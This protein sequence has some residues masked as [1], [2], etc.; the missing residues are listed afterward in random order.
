MLCCF[1]CIWH[2]SLNTNVNVELSMCMA[3][4]IT[5]ILFV[6]MSISL[7]LKT[8]KCKFRKFNCKVH[9]ICLKRY[10]VAHK[11]LHGWNTL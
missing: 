10:M 1:L 8:V 2:A 9:R 7:E 3:F 4:E 6:I 5:V 11:D